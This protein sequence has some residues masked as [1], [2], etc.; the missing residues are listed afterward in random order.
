MYSFCKEKTTL[1]DDLYD[2]AKTSLVVF[3]FPAS[4]HPSTQERIQRSKIELTTIDGQDLYVVDDFFTKEEGSLMRS[5]VQSSTFSKSSYGSSSAVEK[6]ERPAKSMDS[7]ER[8]RF[9]SKPEAPIQEILFFLE[10]LAQETHSEITTLPWELCDEKGNGA[11]AVIANFL[12]EVSLEN[13]MLGKH[14]DCNP[15][16]GISFA[17]PV[18]YEEGSFHEPKFIN[19]APGKPWLISVMLY[20]TEENFSSDHKMGTIFYTKK[21][22]LA[23]RIDC[24]NMRL[25]LFEGDIFHSIEASQ[26]PKETKTWRTSYVFKLVLNP[27]EKEGHPRT[28]L[29]NWMGHFSSSID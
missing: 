12:E 4:S 5:F 3:R 15:E 28:Y 19:G 27:K 16:K 6:G 25:A 11:P 21:G 10:K 22:D 8:W 9:F 17:I 7:K 23:T 20:V 18:L 1:L 2:T 29:R 13:Q 26:I 14:Q 24:K